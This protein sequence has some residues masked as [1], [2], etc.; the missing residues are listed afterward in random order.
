MGL[1]LLRKVVSTEGLAEA[2]LGVPEVLGA[3]VW[4]GKICSL[5]GV[6][7]RQRLANGLLLLGAQLVGGLLPLM[8]WFA[9]RGF[10]LLKQLARKAWVEAKVKPLVA[11]VV[12]VSRLE[13]LHTALL[14]V[15]VQIFI[16]KVAR[17]VLVG[18]G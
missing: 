4:I 17:V 9:A 10:E 11:P 8:L 13:L 14:K 5:V 18:G 3:R 15:A 6:R 7:I 1:K 2:R 16:F 12:A